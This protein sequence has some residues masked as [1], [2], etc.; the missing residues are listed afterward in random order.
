[1]PI[2][3][4]GM[5]VVSPPSN[6]VPGNLLA[7]IVS[8]L[9][10]GTLYPHSL[11]LSTI[12]DIRIFGCFS[13]TFASLFSKPPPASPTK[14]PR[15]IPG[16]VWAKNQVFH[17]FCEEKPGEIA[18]L[19][20]FPRHFSQ[21]LPNLGEKPRFFKDWKKFV[22]PAEMTTQNPPKTRSFPLE[23]PGICPISRKS[24]E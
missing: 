8:N 24:E 23:K 17:R 4:S 5:A 15:F 22:Q 18:N 11:P 10:L 16:V 2:S 21:V 7:E 20:G 13:Q 14:S 19:K 6:G 12:G 9:V 1:M 3:L